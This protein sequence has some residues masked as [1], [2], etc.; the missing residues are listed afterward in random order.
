MKLVINN[1]FCFLAD[2]LKTRPPKSSGWKP[3]V[4]ILILLHN[5]IRNYYFTYV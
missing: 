4:F 1:I 3:D 2:G 5:V